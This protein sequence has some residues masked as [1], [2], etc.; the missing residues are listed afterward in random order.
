MSSEETVSQCIERCRR[1]LYGR[2]HLD[3]NRL[4][5][6]ISAT[7]TTLTFANTLNTIR[8]GVLLGIGAELVYVW[9]VDDTAN[10]AVVE[11]GYFG[12]TAAVASS[13]TLV[14]IDPRFPK[15]LIFESIRDEISSWPDTLYRVETKTI[16]VA[17]GSDAVEIPGIFEDLIGVIDLVKE[18][19]PTMDAWRRS[20]SFK[21]VRNLP[22][23]DV[24]SGLQLTLGETV[25]TATTFQVVMAF[26]FDLSL[27][28]LDTKLV[29]DVGLSVPMLDAI[30]WG[31]KARFL[32]DN[33][34]DRTD[35]GG[36]GE[37]RRADEVPPNSMMQTGVNLLRMRDRRIVEES[38]RLYRDYPIRY[39]AA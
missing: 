35:M 29:E 39:R 10:T 11:R 28:E 2:N 19:W 38:L 3:L 4:S 12:S 32:M 7:D 8:A 16:D 26:P 14:E 22:F 9:S 6:G 31:V 25:S 33:E 36:E 23:S 20:N 27:W 5:A 21:V 15:A 17:G 37:P 13:G 34:V 24:P 18:P 30:A 1:Q